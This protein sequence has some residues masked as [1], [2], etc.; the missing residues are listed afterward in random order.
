LVLEDDMSNSFKEDAI[1]LRE[2]TIV[3]C[4]KSLARCTSFDGRVDL[5]VLLDN[6]RIIMVALCIILEDMRD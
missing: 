1:K 6:Q 3:R 2:E 4:Q 5:E